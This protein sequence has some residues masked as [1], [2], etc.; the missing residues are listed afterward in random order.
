[1]QPPF[2]DSRHIMPDAPHPPELIDHLCRIGGLERRQATRLLA[3]V[4]AFYD[5]TPDAFIR[6]RHRELQLAGFANAAIYRRLLVELGAR[7]FAAEP[8]SERQIRRA[9][10][11]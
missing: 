5:E 2:R 1:M 11:G 9:I 7:R 4:L 6:R 10:Y 3:E 8:R